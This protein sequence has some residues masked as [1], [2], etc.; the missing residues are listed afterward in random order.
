MMYADQR[1]IGKHGIGRFAQ[2][3]LAALEYIPVKLR[4]NP[5][6][7]L[8]SW[9]LARALGDLN[10]TDTFFSPGYNTPLFCRSP[11]AF[12]IHDLSH[13]Y[14]P[15]NSSA[16]IRL[17]Y[18]TVLKRACRHAVK[19]FTVS[20]FTRKQI[21]E[22]TGVQEDKVFNVGCGVDA[23]YHPGPET[24]GL[25]FR[26]LLCVSNRK[27]HKNEF[28]LLD[29]FA[30]AKIDDGIRLVFTG[31]AET[32][33][34]RRIDRHKLADRIVFLGVV[35]EAKLPSL[36]RGAHALVFP[37]LYEG[38]GLPVLEAMAS[39]TPV[40]TSN[41]TAMPEIA[42]EAALL[43]DPTCVDGIADAI[44]RVLEDAALRQALSQK[45]LKRAK[46]FSWT[47]TCS[48]VRQELETLS[49]G[50]GKGTE[51]LKRTA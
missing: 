17:Y 8:D 21:I 15:E 20:E 39:G 27:E 41:V 13:F 12:T 51:S 29:A 40:V 48:R 22:W 38:F 19:I 26:Y 36:Y 14:C 7:P 46:M 23:A 47:R 18:S 50:H 24:Y 11:F 9:R 30:K 42:G 25:P 37:S 33:V 49:G 4:S 28:R 45:G 16:M 31:N 44:Q 35:P 43:V 1:W 34:V 10:G 3:V 5:A 6:G 32:N 2:H